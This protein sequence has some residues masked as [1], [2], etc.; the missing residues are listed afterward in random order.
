MS[1]VEFIVELESRKTMKILL[2]FGGILVMPIE[3]QV[4]C[5]VLLPNCMGDKHIYCKMENVP[6][7]KSAL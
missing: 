6:S 7:V 4:A 5:S 2:K 1:M 3:D